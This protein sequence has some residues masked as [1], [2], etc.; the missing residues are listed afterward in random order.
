MSGLLG[1][2]GETTAAFGGTGPSLDR[3]PERTD[4]VGPGIVAARYGGYAQTARTFGRIAEAQQTAVQGGR[5]V[6]PCGCISRTMT[7]PGSTLSISSLT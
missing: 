7:S 6:A 1:A 4:H 3:S 5:A 2:G